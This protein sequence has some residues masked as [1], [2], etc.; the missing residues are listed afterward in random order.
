MITWHCNYVVRF[1]RHPDTSVYFTYSPQKTAT[2]WTLTNVIGPKRVG[3]HQPTVASAM[4]Y[5]HFCAGIADSHLAK[6]KMESR[7]CGSSQ[8]LGTPQQER[9]KLGSTLPRGSNG[10]RILR[11]DGMKRGKE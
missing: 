1:T 9:S 7:E 10:I 8:K 6:L 3:T 11:S 5:L 2:Y 4:N